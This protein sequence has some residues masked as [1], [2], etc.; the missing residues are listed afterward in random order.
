M[1]LSEDNT[2]ELESYGV[3][4]KNTLKENSNPSEATDVKNGSS[5]NS[6]DFSDNTE[7]LDLPDFD[8][9]DF[10]DMFKD[11][12][13]FATADSQNDDFTSGLDSTLSTDELSNI[14]DFADISIENAA[15]CSD[16]EDTLDDFIEDIDL[17]E[18]IEDSTSFN[19]KTDESNENINEETIDS[20]EDSEDSEISFDIEEE[21]SLDDFMD[22]GFSD[23]S[24]AA[25]NNGYE[26]GKEKESTRSTSD[27]SDSETEELSLDDFMD[28]DFE[29]EPEDISSPKNDIIEDEPP[30]EMDLTF[31]DSVETVETEDNIS[32]E[33]YD[34]FDDDSVAI[35]TEEISLDDFGTVFDT[36]ETPK[37]ETKQVSSETL[38]DTEEI[39]LSDFGI[40]ADAE[41]TPINQDVEEAKKKDAVID[42]DLFVGDENTTSAP[43]VN[44]IKSTE[45][46]ESTE[47]TSQNEEI[48]NISEAQNTAQTGSFVDTSILQQIMTELQN[49]KNDI[50][51]LKNNIEEIKAEEAEN[52]AQE[53]KESEFPQEEKKDEGGFF[54]DLDDDDSIALSFDELDNIMNNA[55]F[56]DN[57]NNSEDEIVL[58]DIT[59]EQEIKSDETPA[60]QEIETDETPAVEEIFVDEEPVIEETPIVEETF[61]EDEISID[62]ITPEQEIESDETPAEQEIETDETPAVEETF[63]DEEPAIEET[64]VV[65]ETF[66]EDEIS[67][68]D[69]TPEQEIKSDETPAVE[70]TFVDEEPVIE[71]TPAVE[72][73]FTEDEI[74]IDDFKPEQEIE[75]DKTPAEQEIE[76]DETPVVEETFVDE[77]PVIEET[78]VVEETFTEDEFSIDDTSDSEESFD[79]II[80]DE[81][82]HNDLS[83][84]FE[85]ES[86]EEPEVESISEI[87]IDDTFEEDLPEEISIPKEDDIFVESDSQNFME[88]DST[89]DESDTIFDE[90]ELTEEPFETVDSFDN[91]QTDDDIPT[92]EKLLENQD[93]ASI[94]ESDK[95]AFERDQMTEQDEVS[96][97]EIQAETQPEQENLEDD[98]IELAN[99]DILDQ[100]P[101]IEE[102]AVDIDT[103]QDNLQED[104]V[105]E[106][107]FD[108]FENISS[109]PEQNSFSVDFDDSLTEQIIEEPELTEQNEPEIQPEVLEN[110]LD[111]KEKTDTVETVQT[112]KPLSQ[113]LMQDVKSLLIYMDQL[114]EDLPE[115][116]IE[117]FANSDKFV[118]FK[119]VFEKLGLN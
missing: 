47:K 28:G 20:I 53:K 80:S 50:N 1:N 54:S 42:Y 74:S 85:N 61:T 34:D 89:K 58:N 39:D 55:A 18:E 97:E 48:N 68:D 46:T 29:T 108:T 17:N 102:T 100:E 60:E 86:L 98:F 115:E 59:P 56:S 72:D 70:E 79:T 94:L 75:S 77:E 114:L 10:S 19:Q 27:D 41:E 91:E 13:Q 69:I 113:D 30:L 8:S 83:F 112:Q 71:E 111:T 95:E 104:S 49:L 23:E 65:E 62:D 38:S 67:I 66:T 82:S 40:D 24:V 3:W 32:V 14:T 118:L 106:T 52:S 105:N 78:P 73:T 101:V 15:S 22:E 31:D 117:E 45:K 16:T 12:S 110:E 87:S 63:V 103:E 4:V 2:K 21:I 25:G 88:S 107:V 99:S 36:S 93:T 57:K 116:K 43:V 90:S 35:E 33:T 26:P 51:T 119:N 37:E 92:V 11:D 5:D 96:V 9:T 7:E 6:Q 84:D 81:Q 64:P 76:T 44:E 109:E